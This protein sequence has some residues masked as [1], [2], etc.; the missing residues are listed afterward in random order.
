M[1]LF[2]Q[3]KLSLNGKVVITDME[4]QPVYSGKNGTFF[5]KRKTYL[6]DNDKKKIAT[7]IEYNGLLN[8][9]FEIRVKGK[10][11]AKIKKKLSLVNQKFHVKKLGWDIKGNFTAKEYTI[12]KGD[13]TVAVIKRTNLVTVLEGYQV[14]ITNPDDAIAVMCV[15]LVLNKILGAKKLDL[16]NKLK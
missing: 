1:E 10:K 7:I 15:V 3:E 8:K 14:T 13:A 2:F 12:T 16:L 6:Y 5:N 4:E 9:G 11:L